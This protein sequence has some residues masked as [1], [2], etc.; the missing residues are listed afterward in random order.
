VRVH[1]V[2]GVE[3]D[4]FVVAVKFNFGTRRFH[5]LWLRDNSLDATTRNTTNGQRLIALNEIAENTTIADCQV[6]K[7]GSGIRVE[8][9][10]CGTTTKFSANWL[11]EHQYD[12]EHSTKLGWVSTRLTTWNAAMSAEDLPTITW[13]VMASSPAAL[14]QWLHGVSK[15]GVGI[16][17]AMP[18]KSGFLCEMARQFGFVR[19][20]NY[21]EYFD[22]RAE[23]TPTNL[24]YTNL[25]LQAHTDN[26]YRDPVPTMQILACLENS[27]DGGESSVVDGFNVAQRLRAEDE[28][29]FQL[30]A[31]YPVRFNYEGDASVALHAKR[32]II[33]CGPDGEI[34]AIRFNNRS[35]API[36]DVPFDV[37]PNFYR[38][39]R[40]FAQLVD[41]PTMAITFKLNP[42]DA[43]IVDNTRVL[44]ARRRFDGSGQRWLQ[45]CYVDKDG[46]ES[47]LRVLERNFSTSSD[48]PGFVF[49]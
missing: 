33:E 25:G 26:P 30:L 37:M 11:V 5:A 6:E 36:V 22:V 44:H 49:R 28:K 9:A 14:R 1:H 8:F 34:L 39:Y 24:A 35:T 38:A 16:V 32:P 17:S 7:D 45:G 27:V 20:T 21:G 48:L 13:P 47:T 41:D 12:V 19:E 3:H 43:F 2:I 18:T 10:P 31:R 4:N 40:R 23:V 42:G 46:L 29:S 15:Y